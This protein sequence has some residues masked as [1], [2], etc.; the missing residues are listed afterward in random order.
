MF[1]KERHFSD[2]L[3]QFAE[4]SQGGKAF[5]LLNLTRSFVLQNVVKPEERDIRRSVG[6]N[7]KA[8]VVAC[9]Q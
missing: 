8:M 4:R 1:A 2:K 5:I 7:A 9:S 3:I 6:A